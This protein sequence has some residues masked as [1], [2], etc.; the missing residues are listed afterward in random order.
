MT[1]A[2]K[3]MSREEFLDNHE[4]DYE[5]GQTRMSR[6]EA[7][8]LWTRKYREEYEGWAAEERAKAAFR[9]AERM[10]AADINLVVAADHFES[11]VLHNLEITEENVEKVEE[12]LDKLYEA[13]EI[14][15]SI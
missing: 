15:E 11:D 13:W 10:E 1:N 5:A 14:L 6:M 2:R 12:A 9:L 8:V 4:A 7:E 3:P